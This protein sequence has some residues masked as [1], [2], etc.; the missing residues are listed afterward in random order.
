M[1]TLLPVFLEAYL[2]APLWVFPLDKVCWSWCC[3]KKEG[4]WRRTGMC[5]LFVREANRCRLAGVDG[6]WIVS[7]LQ[8]RNAQGECSVVRDLHLAGTR[9]YALYGAKTVV[10]GKN[11][12]LCGHPICIRPSVVCVCYHWSWL[13]FAIPSFLALSSGES[14]CWH[15]EQWDSWNR[16]IDFG[17]AG[18]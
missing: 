5:F 10:K 4:W 3:G 9:S 6:F 2:V 1:V 16:S 13:T 7:L 18:E 8:E 17:C 15:T 14:P 11:H 12:V